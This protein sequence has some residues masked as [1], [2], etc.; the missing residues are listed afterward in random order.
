MHPYHRG[1]ERHQVVVELGGCCLVV[2]ELDDHLAQCE[3]L[4]RSAQ[5]VQKVLLMLVARQEQKVLRV[6]A[7]Q[8]EQ[9]VLRVL[10]VQQEQCAQL[11]QAT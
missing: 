9:K 4:V 3:Q 8:Q 11:A 10:A 2:E 6:L 5:Q 1:D 7:V